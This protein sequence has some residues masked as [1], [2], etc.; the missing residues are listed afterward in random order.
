MH[1]PQWVK[2]IRHE[3]TRYIPKEAAPE[4]IQS[5]SDSSDSEEERDEEERAKPQIHPY[6][7]RFW[8]MASS[9]GGGSTAVLVSK[10][11]TQ[12]PDRRG[13]SKLMFEWKSPT[14]EKEYKTRDPLGRLTTE[15]QVWEWMYG[16]GPEV[17]SVM[18][19]TD[20][21]PLLS[22]ESSLREFLKD[23][24]VKQICV[25]CDEGLTNDETEAKCSNNH[26]FGGRPYFTYPS[27]LVANLFS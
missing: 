14:E 19:I 25:F 16:G 23:V 6:R 4:T 8:G 9:P 20:V 11:S 24:K 27:D 15:G 26:S 7:F 3:T 18:G 21:D 13:A 22:K 12:Y 17:P 10:H 1:L 2:K 5:D